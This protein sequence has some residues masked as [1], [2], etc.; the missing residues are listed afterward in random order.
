[1]TEEKNTLRE[2]SELQSALYKLESVEMPEERRE[3]LKTKVLN[4]VVLSAPE[5][6]VDPVL[7]MRIKERVFSYIENQSQKRFFWSNFFAWQKRFVAAFMLFLMVFALVSYVG[8]SPRVVMAGTLTMLDDFT[9]DVEVLREGK[10]LEPY[11]GMEILE[12]DR[13]VTRKGGF[14]TIKFFDDT[15]SRLGDFTDLSI[16]KLFKPQDSSAKTYVEVKVFGGEVWS[17]VVNLPLQQSSFV[18]DVQDLRLSTQKGAFNVK[19][20]PEEVTVDVY[21]HILQYST[22]RASDK[23]LSGKKVVLNQDRTLQVED[24]GEE[25]KTASWVVDNLNSDE[26]YLLEVEERLLLAKMDSLG[27]DIDDEFSFSQ[28]LGERTLLFLTIDDVKQSKIELDLA[29]KNFVAAQIRLENNDLTEGEKADALAAVETF[30]V[31]VREFYDLVA[32]V[33][34]TDSA[35]G[36]ELERYVEDKV[37]S[38]KKVLSL[39][40]KDKLS[41]RAKEVVDELELL[42]ARDERE[43]VQLKAQQALDR[44]FEGD[45]EALTEI[46]QVVNE[47]EYEDKFTDVIAD[48]ARSQ[49]SFEPVVEPVIEQVIVE[50]VIEPV[51]ET[52]TDNLGETPVSGEV[53]DSVADTLV[54][55]NVFELQGEYGVEIEGDKV[56]DPLLY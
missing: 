38:Q 1:M 23:V 15:V 53:I 25:D 24:I 8:V 49:A 2:V 35:Y 30:S 12:K 28:T 36:S 56:L 9:G 16:E 11:F 51:V 41:F 27:M 31:M 22:P 52:V 44:Y 34:T 21:N 55:E 5:F 45:S 42:S 32:E 10:S 4:Q 39:V 26:Q 43:F 3:V 37:I 54:D 13:I 46:S 47:Y 20:L 7:K 40:G 19:V 17:R 33:K 6:F 50:P 29:E 48:L 18:V 14:A